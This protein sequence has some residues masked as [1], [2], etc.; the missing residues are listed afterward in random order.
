[1]RI[2]LLADVHANREAL[3]ACLAHARSIGADRHVFLGDLVGYG[4]DP[5]W[6]LQT[7][8]RMCEGGDLAVIGNHDAAA[9]GKVD[10]RMHRD[11]RLA[12]EW[13]GPR[14]SAR[15]RDFLSALPLRIEDADRLYVHASA[16]DPGKWGYILD[17]EDA[18]LSLNAARSRVVLCGHVH[19]FQLYRQ[20]AGQEVVKCATGT[21]A[22]SGL[23]LTRRWLAVLGSVGQPRDG[24]PAA[25]YALYDTARTALTSYRVAYDAGETARKISA[26]GL[27]EW[28]GT[29]LLEGS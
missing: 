18:E 19:A 4:P 29:R 11:A 5:E 24:N 7:A 17:P 27:P 16:R 2:A 14:L 9:L 21:G 20:G 1:M 6:V 25:A 3:E 22:T 28:L 15:A 8:M 23:D 26:A 12:A 10:R 13:T